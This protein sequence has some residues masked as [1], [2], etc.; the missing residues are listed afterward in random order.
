MRATEI[1]ALR[2][3]SDVWQALGGDPPVRGR[4]KAF[5]REGDNPQAIS[6]NADKMCF[7]DHRDNVGGGVLDLIQQ[8]RGGTRGAALRWLAD[9]NGVALDD[10]QM[11]AAERREF[12]HRRA[13]A[14]QE[15]ADLL[16]WKE[17]MLGALKRARG[18]WWGAYHASLRYILDDGLEAPL[19]DAMATLHEIAE[20]EIELL[21]T[22]IDRL[23]AAPFASILPV[24]RELMKG[25]TV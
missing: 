9:I 25:A 23:A 4:A 2:P 24:F 8:V 15:G 1:C 21:N 5:F 10:R 13:Q 11:T 20:D 19:G 3:I 7:F 14:Q 12:A 18:R 22:K 16:D 17:G 6:L